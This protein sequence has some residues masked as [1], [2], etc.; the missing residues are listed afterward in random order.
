MRERNNGNLIWTL[1]VP[2]WILDIRSEPTRSG[3]AGHAIRIGAEQN[4]GA[5]R[6]FAPKAQHHVRTIEMKRR[7][8]V[9]IVTAV[10]LGGALVGKWIAVVTG[11]SPTTM[12]KGDVPADDSGSL[13]VDYLAFGSNRGVPLIAVIWKGQTNRPPRDFSVKLVT[14][15]LPHAVYLNGKM[16]RAE[17]DAFV[18]WAITAEQEPRRVPA[19][20]PEAQRFFRLG[21][22]HTTEEALTFWKKH[23]EPGLKSG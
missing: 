22:E 4:A 6:R 23:V 7:Q 2:C 11:P 17:R 13:G 18:L 3:S 12:W 16:I 8:I 10:V 5:Y 15:E 14:S 21:A 19:A 9:S 1:D 20:R